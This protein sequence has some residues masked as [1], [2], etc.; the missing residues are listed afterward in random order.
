[1]KKEVRTIVYDEELDMEA[2]YFQGTEKPFPN[3]FHEHYVIGLMENGLRNL[4]CRNRQY[5]IGEN[6]ILLLNPGDNHGCVQADHRAMDY[7]GLNIPREVML[8][9]AGEI[10]GKPGSFPDFLKM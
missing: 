3:H 4:S 5:M 8:D 2:Y 7:R 6:Q 9:F 10:T 1:M